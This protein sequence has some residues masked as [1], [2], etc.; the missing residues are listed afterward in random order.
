MADNIAYD[1]KRS[2][3]RRV[4]EILARGIDENST[5]EIRDERKLIGELWQFIERAE[6]FNSAEKPL[7][8]PGVTYGSGKINLPEGILNSMDD[9]L[10]SFEFPSIKP[11][12][13]S[14]SLADALKQK[15]SSL[16]GDQDLFMSICHP[17]DRNMASGFLRQLPSVKKTDLEYRVV[18]PEKQIRWV[19]SSVKQVFDGEGNL[20]RLDVVMRDI[21]VRRNLQIVLTRINNVLLNLGPDFEQNINKLT[22]LFGEL[23]GATCALYNRL[24]EGLLCSI[25]QW[26]TPADYQAVDSPEGHICYD[27]I[28]DGSDNFLI[29]RNLDQTTY[30]TSDPNVKPYNLKTY[31]GKAVFCEGAAVGSICAVFQQDFDP[32]IEQINLLNMIANAIGVEE[33][34]R[35]ASEKLKETE[36]KL[37]V[38]INSTPDIIC[39][40]DS[41]GR[42]LQANDSI[43][44]LYCLRNVDYRGKSET[45]LAEFT[46]DIYKDAFKNC[47]DSDKKAWDTGKQSRTEETIPDNHGNLH[48]FDVIKVPLYNS[49]NSRRGLVVFGRDITPRIEDEKQT[50][51][52]NESA[53]EFIELGDHENIYEYIGQKVHKLAGN[54]IVM[55]TSFDESTQHATLQSLHGVGKTLDKVLKILRQ[56]PVGMS[57]Y[58]SPERKQD[59]LFQKLTFR[60]D[61][62]EMLSGAIS[63][64]V[65]KAFEKLFDIGK[66]YE[67][68]FARRDYLL[69]DVTIIMPKNELLSNI[70]VIEA[71]IKVAA[72]ALNRRQVKEALKASEESYRGLFN[73]IT[74]AIYIQDKN[75]KFLDVNDGAIEMYGYPKTRFVGNTPEFLSAPG[76]NDSLDIASI[77][78]KTF[79][80]IPQQIEFWGRR[81]NG[82]IFPK[83]I[84][85]YKGNYFGNEVAI[86]IANDIT[87]QHNMISQ[88]VAAKEVAETNLM[89]TNSIVSA[90]P[91]SIF[92][93]DRA[94]NLIE[95]FSQENNLQTN[96]HNSSSGRLVSEVMSEEAAELTR[97]NID[98]VLKSGHMHKY[99]YSILSGGAK[100]YFEAS[101]VKLTSDRVLA[102]IRNTTEKMQLVEALYQAVEKAEESDRL[103]TSFL[104]NISHE[105]RTPMNGIVGFANLLTQKGITPDDVS[106]YN[107]IINSCSNQLLSIITDIVSIATLEAGQ[108]KVREN[109]ANLNEMMH[110]VYHQF[111]SKAGEKNLRLSFNPGLNDDQA[112]VITDDTKLGQVLTNLIS[113]AVKF[114]NEGG[115]QVSYAV[116]GKYVKFCVEDTGIGI[117][118]EMHEFIFDRFRQ[119]NI[120]TSSNYG[121]TGLGLSISKS[122]IELMGG[123]IWLESMP[124]A[125]SKFYFTIPYKPVGITAVNELAD[126]SLYANLFAEQ[127][128]IMIVEDE[129]YNYKLLTKMLQPLNFDIIWKENGADAIKVCEENSGIDL[130]LMDLKL[131]G[132][133]GFEASREIRKIRPGLVIIAQS[134]LALSGDREK[135]V[136]SGCTD[137]ISKP[138]VRENLIAMLRKYLI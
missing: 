37:M 110:V 138:I 34:R 38:L 112:Q 59:V 107:S 135:A 70:E 87:E 68:G 116:E 78:K 50:R 5:G 15:V 131:P 49:D 100:K 11:L 86:V 99:D 126:E 56:H 81:S 97:L 130:V 14:Q 1:L 117:T 60:K 21:T 33:T 16:L 47:G 18:L 93:L 74:S 67:M 82:E 23:F 64:P 2:L 76:K 103:K 39:F 69:G 105:I 20:V 58:L 95:S 9:Y 66:I 137:Y 71:F 54:S 28:K 46:A 125:G 96:S 124:G 118:V 17:E 106:E 29:V 129:F 8:E 85:F 121:G 120:A 89:K 115:I 79:D 72:V 10:I 31:I 73:S 134:A 90:F 80:G 101:M 133:D 32:G 24:E 84:R 88:L 48:I 43:L 61:L 36:E 104:H 62:Y 127:K 44:N 53:L 26:S 91:D 35:K 123:E 77:L 30:Y 65:A 109:Q 22:G 75:G 25:G 128:T 27:V 3:S 113:N 98:L 122:Y 92:I 55:V 13:V 52:L 94:G 136:N 7:S 119:A 132:T 114:T 19:H 42:W 63:R 6:S 111:I 102:V 83:D 4:Q 45:E 40:K 108:E 12:F 57:S 51:F 41:E